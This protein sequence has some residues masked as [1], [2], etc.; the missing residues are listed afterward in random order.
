MKSENIE[1]GIVLPIG[2]GKA[3]ALDT[4]DSIQAYCH[5][6][7]ITVIVDDCTQDGTYEAV[8]ESNVPDCVVLRNE[9][10]M[11]IGRLVHTLCTGFKYLLQH[12]DL[13]VVLRLDQDALIIKPNLLTEAGLYAASHPNVGIFGVYNRDYN[14]PRKY[15]SHTKLIDKEMNPI[16]RLFGFSPSYAQLLKRAEARGYKRGD[17]VFGGAYF[18]TRKC[19]VAMHDNGALD[20]PYIWHSRLMEDVYFSIAAV[21]VGFEMGHFAFPDGP[22]LL[23]WQGLPFPAQELAN[24]HA[25]LVH[26]VDKGPNTDV[27]ANG[28][29]TAREYFRILRRC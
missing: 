11:K 16:R 12:S 19:L 29:V 17:N 22:L 23:E 6:P 15:T 10:R 3:A 18:L 4:L 21:A 24:S 1:Y 28:G 8:C 13:D 20:P 14:R 26:S 2:P 9:R 27:A 7:H 5:E 25:K